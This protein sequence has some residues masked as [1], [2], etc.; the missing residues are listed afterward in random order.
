MIE[1]SIPDSANEYSFGIPS[2]PCLVHSILVQ[3]LLVRPA[4]AEVAAA[5][6]VVVMLAGMPGSARSSCLNSEQS[7]S[8]PP[9]A[10]IERHSNSGSAV[11]AVV[12]AVEVLVAVGDLDSDS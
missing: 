11:A 6:L 7:C 1:G 3:L 12:A 4:V 5:I 9:A 8:F 2:R 10:G